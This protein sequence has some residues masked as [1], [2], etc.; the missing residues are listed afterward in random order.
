MDLTFLFTLFRIDLL[1]KI[2]LLIVVGLYSIFTIFLFFQIRS[3]NKLLY[4]ES[5]NASFIITVLCFLHILL[6]ISLFLYIL[7]IL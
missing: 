4:I 3:L 1:I 2:L 7:A 5:R 6:V